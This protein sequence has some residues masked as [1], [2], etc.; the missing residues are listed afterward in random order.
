MEGSQK[1]SRAQDAHRV[2]LGFHTCLLWLPC[3]LL[4]SKFLV[5]CVLVT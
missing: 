2:L 1:G 3:A 4:I 5:L